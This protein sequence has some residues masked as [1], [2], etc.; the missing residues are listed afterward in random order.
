MHRSGA[1]RISSKTFDE[2][3]DNLNY[4]RD[5]IRQTMD[6]VNEKFKAIDIDVNEIKD[7]AETSARSTKVLS[8]Q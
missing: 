7:F 8:S 6:L 4:L 1:R 5:Y 3:D 2:V